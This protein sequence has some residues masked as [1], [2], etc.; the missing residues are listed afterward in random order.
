MTARTL[1][2]ALLA[3]AG[4]ALTDWALGPV[5]DICGERRRGPRTLE[6]HVYVDHGDVG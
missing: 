3:D 1:A 4:R 5:C 2:R 6:L